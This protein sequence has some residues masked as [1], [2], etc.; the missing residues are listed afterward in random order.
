[1]PLSGWAMRRDEDGK[2]GHSFQKDISQ[3]HYLMMCG[4]GYPN[5]KHNFEGA[6]RSFELKFPEN[7]AI[8]TVPESPMF[9]IEQASQFVAPRLE[10]LRRAG[11]EYAENFAINGD[12]MKEICSPMIPEEIY[13]QFANGERK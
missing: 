11:R 13:S 8:I 9:N 7:S 2:Y 3:I 4:C 1:M 5:S 12:L 10:A 6:V